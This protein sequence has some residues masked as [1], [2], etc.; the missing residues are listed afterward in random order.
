MAIRQA[1]LERVELGDFYHERM[2]NGWETASRENGL[3]CPQES[4]GTVTY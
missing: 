3:I 1:L 2:F 4:H